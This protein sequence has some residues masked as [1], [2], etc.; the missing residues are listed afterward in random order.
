MTA[1]LVKRPCSLLQGLE[2]S[3]HI[4]LIAAALKAAADVAHVTAGQRSQPSAAVQQAS[5]G[6][7]S[8][9]PGLLARVEAASSWAPIRHGFEHLPNPNAIG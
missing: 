8:S 9:M 6:F 4:A 3:P 5:A 7:H 1:I 2:G